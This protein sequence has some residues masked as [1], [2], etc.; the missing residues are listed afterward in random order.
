VVIEVFGRG[1]QLS[2][3]IAIP[4]L[5]D[6]S[7]IPS[8]TLHYHVSFSYLALRATE[9]LDMILLF[10]LLEYLRFSGHSLRIDNGRL[11]WIGLAYG[12]QGCQ[13]EI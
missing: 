12:Y 6:T 13:D 4:L 2:L 10:I 11:N 7:V 9:L 3:F 5:C 8:D 1:E